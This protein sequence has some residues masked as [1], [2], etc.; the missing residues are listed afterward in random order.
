MQYEQEAGEIRRDLPRPSIDTGMGLERCGHRAAGCAHSVFETDL[1]RTLI[2]AAESEVGKHA[3]GEDTASFRVIA[4]H[5]RSTSFLIADGVTP[6]N[7]GRG[8]VLRRIMRRAMRHAYLLGAGE[9]LMH[10]LVPTLTAEMGEAYPDLR[11]AQPVIVET[12]RAEEERFHRTLGRGLGLLDEA[13]AGLGDGD[14]LSGETAFKLYDTYGFPLDLTQDA[15]RPRGIS[16]DTAGFDAAMERQK[17]MARESWSGSG[18]KAQGGVWL[19]LRDRL[20][21]TRFEGHGQSE[22][23]A[24]TLALVHGDEEVEIGARRAT[25]CLPSVRRHAVLRRGRRSGGRPGRGRM[26]GRLGNDPAIRGRWPATCTS[27]CWRS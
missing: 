4:D 21:P 1:F 22:V 20:G 25:R 15:V 19:A 12:L 24:E 3:T 17:T 14:T 13:T 11:R 2:A 16:V 8:Y 9:P 27:M 5:L 10:R 6:S 26:G 23:I 18:Q 7:E